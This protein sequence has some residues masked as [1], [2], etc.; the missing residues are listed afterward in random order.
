MLIILLNSTWNHSPRLSSGSQAL[1]LCRRASYAWQ[2]DWALLAVKAESGM[3]EWSCSPSE[4]LHSTEH[5]Q[6]RKVLTNWCRLHLLCF[7]TNETI[8][9][10]TSKISFICI[11]SWSLWWFTTPSPFGHTSRPTRRAPTRTELE[12]RHAFAQRIECDIQS[13]PTSESYFLFV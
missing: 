8:S 10:I 9:F 6:Q 1:L 11:R 13:Q 7:L 4:E 5:Q 2:H 3:M 12:Q